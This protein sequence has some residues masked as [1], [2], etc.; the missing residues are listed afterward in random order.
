MR[1]LQNLAFSSHLYR[2]YLHQKYSFVRNILIPYVFFVH[3]TIGN[4]NMN[5]VDLVSIPH[6]QD[7]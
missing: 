3:A 7:F 2:L 1:F 6:C 5:K 4:T